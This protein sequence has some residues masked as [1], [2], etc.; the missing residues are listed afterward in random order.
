[1][2]T[3]RQLKNQL[4]KDVGT[5]E[6]MVRSDRYEILF[7]LD[8]D[9]IPD[10][11]LLDISR[12]GDVDAIAMDLTGN[13]E[14]NFYLIDNDGNGIADEISFYRDGDDLPVKSV[15][16]RSVEERLVDSAVRIHT[17]LVSPNP[18]AKEII[19]ALED[20]EK[21]IDSEYSKL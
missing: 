18:S 16:G 8:G 4:K 19:D 11:G 15:F 14:F 3:L 10:I 1:M 7:D 9:K 20:L 2:G 6:L 12:D 21:F 5:R 17:L 13:G